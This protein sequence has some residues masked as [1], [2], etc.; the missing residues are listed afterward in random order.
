MP[1]RSYLESANTPCGANARA[2]Y[3]GGHSGLL[4]AGLSVA[5]C[6]LLLGKQPLLAEGLFVIQGGLLGWV[7]AFGPGRAW[8]RLLA[9]WLLAFLPVLV[10][11]L[12]FWTTLDLLG[13]LFGLLRGQGIFLTALA[14]AGSLLLVDLFWPMAPTWEQPALEL[15]GL[16]SGADS[17]DKD[18]RARVSEEVGVV[19]KSRL[20]EAGR[21]EPVRKAVCKQKSH[22][23]WSMADWGMLLA[24]LALSLTLA[25]AWVERLWL[26]AVTLE[27]LELPSRW[28]YWLSQL[29]QVGW[30]AGLASANAL[31][32]LAPLTLLRQRGAPHEGTPLGF[33]CKA[34][35]Y[36][37]AGSLPLLFFLPLEIGLELIVIVVLAAAIAAWFLAIT[38]QCSRDKQQTGQPDNAE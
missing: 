4:T 28:P 6:L 32:I 34:A 24:L 23:Q 1:A 31:L 12:L 3:L 30:L 17:R 8:H 2:E 36:W 25:Q 11:A 16:A 19:A 13:P 9:T 15:F 26:L 38:L 21:G 35:G 29:R 27:P 37:A 20:S 18:Q 7:L 10:V 14:T 33:V 22:R 5:G